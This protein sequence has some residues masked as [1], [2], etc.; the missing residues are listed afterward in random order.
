[1]TRFSQS[2]NSR[3]VNSNWSLGAVVPDPIAVPLNLTAPSFNPSS[4]KIGV[5]HV[6]S[7]DTWDAYDQREY[8]IEVDGVT[9]ANSATYTPLGE[10][11]TLSMVVQV[12]AMNTGGAW[13][14]WV[15]SDA[16]TVT[17]PKAVAANA[18]PDVSYDEQSGDRYLSIAGDFTGTVGGEWSVV[19]ALMDE[20]EFGFGVVK[21][22]TDTV[23]SKT[24][25]VTYTNSGGA[26]SSSF[27][28]TVSAVITGFYYPL[29]NS[30]TDPT[31]LSWTSKPAGY[32]FV[33][34]DGIYCD[35][36][37]HNM[38]EMFNGNSTFNDPDIN[39]WDVSTVG[40]FTKAFMNATAFSQSL[41][42]WDMSGASSFNSTFR[43]ATNFNGAIGNWSVGSANNLS[44]MFDGC[45]SFNQDLSGWCVLTSTSEPSAFSRGTTAWVLPKPV[46]GTCP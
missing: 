23:E 32:T 20:L 19:G 45:V 7:G 16:V 4:G 2:R 26:E 44:Y 30:A 25:T 24:I 34:N 42:S 41:S 10:D 27:T 6:G 39:L 29:T 9:I 13:S 1:M 3:L 33:P 18:L 37:I 21:I 17:Y 12:R 11:D 40:D 36:P 8:R 28:A 38:R 46:W 5:E 43:Y 14:P 31:S 15:S 22:S 35:Q